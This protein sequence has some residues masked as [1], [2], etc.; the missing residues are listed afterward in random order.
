MN[1]AVDSTSPLEAAVRAI[2]VNARIVRMLLDAGAVPRAINARCASP[3]HT[4]CAAREIEIVKMLLAAGADV[5][6]TSGWEETPL[7]VAARSGEPKL[8]ALLLKHGADPRACGKDGM[9]ALHWAVQPIA[10]GLVEFE[11]NSRK[12]VEKALES[13]PPPSKKKQQESIDRAVKMMQL[14]VDAG[15]DINQPDKKGRTPLMY[16]FKPEIA[17]WL[18]Q[19][20]ANLDAHDKSRRSARNWLKRCGIE[21]S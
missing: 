6:E 3:F 8:L 2:P 9:T 13:P 20:G 14:L 16:A 10:G 21:T 1:A 18:V 19:S 7:M 12:D 17:R 4:A 11:I 15:S 5:N